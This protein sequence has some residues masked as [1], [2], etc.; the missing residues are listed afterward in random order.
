[1][2]R[3]LAGPWAVAAIE[4]CSVA[5]RRLGLFRPMHL[6]AHVS[7]TASPSLQLLLLCSARL[8]P[9]RSRLVLEER[10]ERGRTHK[11][12]RSRRYTSRSLAC[13]FF[14]VPATVR[15]APP[16]LS[17]S[18]PFAGNE[19]PPGPGTPFPSRCAKRNIPN[20]NVSY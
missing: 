20:P 3:R 15:R 5:E 16:P 7:E 18:G 9:A 12:P 6:S 13:A 19:H 10:K 4:T 11:R 14:P 8:L 1:M 17:S 2:L